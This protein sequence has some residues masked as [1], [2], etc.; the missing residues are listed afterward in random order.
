MGSGNKALIELSI[1]VSKGT[2]FSIKSSLD[3][4]LIYSS[5]N[6][7]AAF[8]VL[9]LSIFHHLFQHN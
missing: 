9:S 5:I 1:P 2:S 8:C 6:S 3:N 7:F 4:V